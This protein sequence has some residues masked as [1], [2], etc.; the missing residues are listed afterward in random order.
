M[1]GMTVEILREDPLFPFAEPGPLRK[2]D[3]LVLPDEPRCELIFGRLY[4]IPPKTVEHQTVALLLARDLH[5]IARQ[6]AGLAVI[7]PFDVT[8][9]DHSV[10]QPDVI[11]LS[12]SRRDMIAEEGVEGAPDLLVEV[13]LPG[14]S[15]RERYEKSKLYAESGVREYRSE[16]R[17]VGK[18]CRSRWSPYH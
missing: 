17:R 3:Y 9:A 5:Q 18:E 14:P 10:V 13:L 6:T 12:A 11:Y 2:Q 4:L 16:E 15:R 7:A 1:N 8:L